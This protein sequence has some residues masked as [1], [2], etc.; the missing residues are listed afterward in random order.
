MLDENEQNYKWYSG[1]YD[2]VFKEVMLKE[3]NIDLLKLLLEH[4]L[5]VEI[6]NIKIKNGEQLRENIH[7][8]GMRTDLSLD[9]NIGYINVE[10][11]SHPDKYVHPRN[12]SYI[13]DRYSHDVKVSETYNEKTMYIQ[14]NLTYG[15]MLNEDNKK[16]K[17]PKDTE[18]IREYKMMD[19]TG[20]EFIKNLIIYEINMD[21]YLLLWYNKDIKKLEKEKIL[22]MLGLDKEGLE[23]LSG[24]DKVVSKYMKEVNNVNEDPEFREYISYEED[25]RKIQNTLLEEAENKGIEK[26]IEQGIKQGIE[27]GRTEGINSSKIEITKNMLT[28]GISKE[29][30]SEI[31]GLSLN[32][33]NQIKNDILKQ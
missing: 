28:K 12:F 19:K 6:Y 15:F 11:N 7:I 24:Y 13:T 18:P 27:Q 20:K 33:I 32:T 22:V 30:I 17:D 23:E 25:M 8:K 2:R 29:D 26:G 14:I 3:D 1:K 21:Y 9:T 10:I 4:I 5:K 16:I 31:T